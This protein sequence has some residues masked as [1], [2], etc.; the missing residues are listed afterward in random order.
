MSQP[1]KIRQIK[2]ALI[3][4]LG[5]IDDLTMYSRIPDS[6]NVPCAWVSAHKSKPQAD[7]QQIYQGG[8][9]QYN[10][11]IEVVTNRQDIETAQ[12]FLDDYASEDGPFLQRLHAFEAGDALHDLI[13]NNIEVFT[14]S[15]YGS[16][17]IGGAVYL[18][19]QLEIQL[20]S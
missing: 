18:G 8:Q 6:A 2:A 15:R 10:F 20:S 9:V 4:R 19:F 12:D 13:G 17:K 1:G 3:D 16:Y 11:M 7:Y 5:N 14:A